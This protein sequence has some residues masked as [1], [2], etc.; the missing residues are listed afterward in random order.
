MEYVTMNYL[1]P[2]FSERVHEQAIFNLLL[3]L[4]HKDIPK[5]NTSLLFVLNQ[6]DRNSNLT[7]RNHMRLD[8]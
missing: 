8:I 3:Y 5:E 1:T 7:D 2:Y 4:I 6:L